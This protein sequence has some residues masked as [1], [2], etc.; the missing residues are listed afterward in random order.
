MG[1]EDLARRL[2][3][4]FLTDMPAQLAALS[5]AIGSADTSGGL[6]L[7]HSIRGAA[8]NVS[9]DSMS[10]IASRIEAAM[11]EGDIQMAGELLS[12]LGSEFEQ[13]GAA[14]RRFIAG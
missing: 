11:R 12:G 7:A 14:L 8:A 13:A 1:D 4:R 6:L 9:G 5:D 3:G 2:V 10:G